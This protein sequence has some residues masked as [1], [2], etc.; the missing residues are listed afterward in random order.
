MKKLHIK[1]PLILPY[2]PDEKDS[3]I[4]RL[5]DTLKN[6]QG[7]KK[8]HVAY[9]KNNGEPELCFHYNPDIISID[10]ITFLGNKQELY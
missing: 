2:L 6:E 3:C 10:Q 5:I 7:I 4:Q 1:I 9:E 8:I